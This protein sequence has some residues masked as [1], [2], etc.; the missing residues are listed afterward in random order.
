MWNID[1]IVLNFQ[2][3]KTMA[4]PSYQCIFPFVWSKKQRVWDVS[5]GN[6]NIFGPKLAFTDD[7]GRVAF[8]LRSLVLATFF[9]F[10]LFHNL[11]MAHH[12]TIFFSRMPGKIRI[13]K[14]TFRFLIILMYC[15]RG[16]F[17]KIKSIC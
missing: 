6:I 1:Q 9:P 5:K 7:S 11:S 10:A 16:F 17:F 8:L 14:Q 12:A 13:T 15:S 4:S 2:R 3:L